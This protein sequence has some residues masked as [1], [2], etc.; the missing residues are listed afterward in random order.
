MNEINKIFFRWAF[1]IS[2]IIAIILFTC[3]AL[4]GKEAF[5]LLLNSNLG[6]VAD[7][8]FRYTTH[9]GDGLMWI[10]LLFIFFRY[11][12]N[13]LPLLIAAFACSTII[14]QVFKYFIMPN[15]PRP[16]LAIPNTSLIHFVHGVQ[17]HEI[18][19]FP[20]GHTTTAFVFFLLIAAVTNRIIFVVAG[21]IVALAV[22]YSRVY[23]AQHFPLDV[24]GGII[25][26][27]LT[28]IL[29]LLVQ[30]RWSSKKKLQQKL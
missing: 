27:L 20:S 16:V 18:S 11:R 13:F 5:F 24:A 10:P 6:V 14:T 9:L 23:L 1:M 30:S 29:S 12:K 7:Y 25:A 2:L 17:V 26:A 4:I 28:M 22:G 15:E 21:F 3:N 19:S 8:F